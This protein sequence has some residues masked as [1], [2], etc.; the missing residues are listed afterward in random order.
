MERSATCLETS[1][2][3]AAQSTENHQRK[4]ES[5]GCCGMR[6]QAATTST[7]TAVGHEVK[8]RPKVAKWR[9][10]VGHEVKPRPA[11]PSGDPKPR[12]TGVTRSNHGP[13]WRPTVGHEVKPRPKV[14]K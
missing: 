5:S 9:P 3:S 4:V 10:T 1:G 11:T 14:A 6:S 7:L 8:P 13:K 12:P 2:R